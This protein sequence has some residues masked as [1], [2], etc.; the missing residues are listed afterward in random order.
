M[1]KIKK[2]EKITNKKNT[3]ANN[4][5]IIENNNDLDNGKS[6][7]NMEKKIRN[8]YKEL[9]IHLLTIFI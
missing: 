2:Q 4:N 5:I 7:D 1:K 9:K 6:N 8:I 3:K